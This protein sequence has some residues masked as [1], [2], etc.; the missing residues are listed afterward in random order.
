MFVLLSVTN[1]H[2]FTFSLPKHPLAVKFHEYR[3][4]VADKLHKLLVNYQT[5]L[6]QHR[7]D[8]MSTTDEDSAT[9][10]SSDRNYFD[11]MMT[12][13]SVRDG[14]DDTLCG[15]DDDVS[16][17]PDRDTADNCDTKVTVTP[18]QVD[19][20]ATSGGGDGGD[21]DLLES[22][23]AT[24]FEYDE[25][26]DSAFLKSIRVH[27]GHVVRG[28]KGPMVRGPQQTGR[29]A[30]DRKSIDDQPE[31][32][33]EANEQSK[34]DTNRD[35][36]SAHDD[37]TDACT[38]D[39]TTQHVQEPL[40]SSEVDFFTTTADFGLSVASAVSAVSYDKALRARSHMRM[41]NAIPLAAQREL[42]VSRYHVHTA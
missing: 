36:V 26:D 1:N 10:F 22:V 31:T 37:V 15:G 20:A 5:T 29:D 2:F 34:P 8:V 11:S 42:Q 32:K 27:Q 13:S 30:A 7:D 18:S 9:E 16:G 17:K 35:V 33:N 19:G 28:P 4:G 21:G 41:W 38:G 14:L 6:A 25:A 39:D 12:S 3:S 23:A 40:S 24:E